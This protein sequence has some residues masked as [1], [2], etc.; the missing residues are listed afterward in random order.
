MKRAHLLSM[1]FA[2]TASWAQT[3]PPST[4]SPAEAKPASP[5]AGVSGAKTQ[6]GKPPLN[7]AL[8]PFTPESI[9]K[10]VA[11]HQDEIQACYEETLAN[12]EKPVEGRIKTSFV[13]TAEGLVKKPKVITKGTT[14]KD[15][16]LHACVVD[17]LSTFTFP[18]PHDRREHP[19]EYPFNLKAIR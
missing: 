13:I 19:V 8:M 7:L 5:D 18:K 16:R 1:L 11:Y 6:E 17:A 12:K 4:A 9:K 3:T 15:P 2:A 14:L 10:V